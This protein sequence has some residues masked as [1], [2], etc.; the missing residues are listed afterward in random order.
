MFVCIFNN[1]SLELKVGVPGMSCW[2][3]G[4]SRASAPER[5]RTTEVESRTSDIGQNV[6]FILQFNKLPSSQTPYKTN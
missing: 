5:L 3:H 6:F 2:G 4:G 1:H